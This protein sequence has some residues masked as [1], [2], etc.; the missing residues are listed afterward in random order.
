MPEFATFNNATLFCIVT[1]CA[2]CLLFCARFVDLCQ[3][4]VLCQVC[5]FVCVSEQDLS[6]NFFNNNNLLFVIT[7]EIVRTSF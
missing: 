4:V 3:V 2:S 7:R 1:Y 6:S 5:C